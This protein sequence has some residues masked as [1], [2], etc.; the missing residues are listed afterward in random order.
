MNIDEIDKKLIAR[1]QA[2]LPLVPRPFARLAEEVGIC[3]AEAVART[4]RLAES[5]IMRRFGATL[6]HQRSG[7]PS[8]VMVAWKI[9]PERIREVGRRLARFRHVTHCYWRRPCEQFPYNLFTMVHGHSEE[10][11]RQLVAEMAEAIGGAEHQLLFSLE[12]L[13][14]SSMRYFDHDGGIHGAQ[15]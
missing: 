9:A 11:C 5:G 8:N 14:K 6:R 12:E 2:D 13:K 3:E 1:L 7:F 10:H 4:R 15:R